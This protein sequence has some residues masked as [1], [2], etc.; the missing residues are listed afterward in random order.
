[1][2]GI[3]GPG[4]AELLAEGP[5]NRSIYTET[6]LVALLKRYW[7]AA[8]ILMMVAV[9]AAVIGYLRSRVAQ[10]GE[11]ASTSVELGAFRFQPVDQTSTVYLFDLYA[12]VDPSRRHHADE[13][14]TQMKMEI[15]E[16]SEQMLR[17]VDPQWL[18]DPTQAQIR[19][20]LMEVVQKHLDEA[21]VQRV[22]ITN[23]LELPV[24][25]IGA[26][27]TTSELVRK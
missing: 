18:T 4:T 27:T 1:L 2:T 22:L 26:T 24:Q 16:A 7:A 8:L 6:I 21:L 11:V 14:L 12:V 3:T 23:W 19:R 17:Q 10:V 20:R 25:A 13:R 5:S 9:H 15:H